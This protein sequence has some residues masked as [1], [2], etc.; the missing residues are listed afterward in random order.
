MVAT[1]QI[2]TAHYTFKLQLSKIV[3]CEAFGM[4]MIKKERFVF[5][6]KKGRMTFSSNF[7]GLIVLNYYEF[8]TDS[9]QKILKSLLIYKYHK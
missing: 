2:Y 3:M 8:C 6:K 1:F 4:N 9:T 5:V 7:S